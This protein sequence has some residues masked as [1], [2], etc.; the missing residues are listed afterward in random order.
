MFSARFTRI[1]KYTLIGGATLGTAASLHGNQYQLN[2]IG[3][4]RLSRAA[5]T[6]FKVGVIY[7]KDLYGPNLDKASK[8]Y[9]E[10]KSLC[11]KKSA[12]KL[13][14]LCCINKG[15][16]IKVGQHIAALDYLLPSEYVQTMKVLHCHAPEN[17]IEDIYRVIKEELKQEVN[18]YAF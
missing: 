17:P 9:I 1:L 13:L 6:V 10:L 11:H 7:K 2:S 18:N 15:V 3:I 5:I 16:Y 12:E 4:V 14:E 8:E